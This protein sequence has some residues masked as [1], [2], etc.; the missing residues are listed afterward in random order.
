MVSIIIVYYH[1]S[2]E[3]FSSI[4]AISK[5]K[6]ETDFEVIIVDNDEE[7]RIKKEL[8][9]KFPWVRYIKSPANNGFGAGNNLGAKHAKGEYLFFLNPDTR[10]FPKT[11]DA[12][13]SFLEN[14][15]NVGIVAPQLLH[16]DK[17]PF[18]Q[19]G[20][21]LLNPVRGMIVLSFIN[22][23]LPNNPVSKA[24]WQTGW[25]KTKLK[26]VDVAPGTA[27]MIRKKLYDQMHGFD[28][29][30]F[31]Y[32][33]EFDLCKRIR[34]KGYKI[35]ITPKAQIIHLWGKGGTDT[36]PNIKNIYIQSR[37]YYFKKHY[38]IFNMLLV[39]T[40]ARFGKK[41]FFLFIILLLGIIL[42]LFVV[43]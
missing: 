29:H 39:E 35:F 13:L 8:K 28:E 14:Q 22:K 2:E 38:G 25:N 23:I 32:F 36:A 12:L 24:Y 30:F 43:S 18:E 9:K 5:N 10:I 17:T 42:L 4:E 7:I 37:I 15:T 41:Q 27:F 19:Q 33:E 1:A 16:P 40:F 11:V 34:E 6:P 26:Q 31:L 21:M 3:L 20:C